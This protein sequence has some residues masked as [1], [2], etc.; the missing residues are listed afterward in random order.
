MVRMSILV[1]KNE[2]RNLQYECK[3][4]SWSKTRCDVSNDIDAAEEARK[5]RTI[6]K[7]ILMKKEEQTQ[8]FLKLTQ[9]RALLQRRK[10]KEQKE[11]SVKKTIVKTQI[12]SFEAARNQANKTQSIL[13][14]RFTSP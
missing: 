8:Q 9:E 4:G 10:V 6:T 11:K 5:I 2:Q 3:L 1:D 14:S 7:D 12:T 13:T